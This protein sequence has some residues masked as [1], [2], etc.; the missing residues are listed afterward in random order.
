MM[1]NQ[2]TNID[3]V[4]SL[5][6]SHTVQGG[7][8]TQ[9]A[10]RWYQVPVTGG[11]IGSAT[12][13]STWNPDSS[14][15]FMPSVDVD[16][17]GDMA[18]GYSVS[19]STQFPAI[20]YAGRLASD[21]INTLSQTE[22]S[23]IEGTG[24]QTG[25]CGGSACTRW[26]DYSAM[27]LDPNGCTFWYANEYYVTS[28]L[29][30]HTRIGSF[31]FP[32]CSP[33]SDT[34]PP[35][36]SSI[37]RVDANPTNG[38]TVH[39]TVVFSESVTGVDSSDF[40][41][42]NTG[43]TSPSITGVSGS[44]TSY[45]VTASTGAGSGSL[46]LNLVDDD[47]ITDAAGNKLGGTGTGNGNLIG[48]VYT[49][50]KTFPSVSSIV[51]AD[52]N[53]TNAGS[54]HWTVTFSEPVT[55]VDSTDFALANTGLS[56]PSISGVSGSGSTYT[57]TA[58]TGT[59]S[60]SLGL[61]LT[62]DDSITDSTGNKL[63]GT[64]TGNGDFTGQVYAIDTIAPT[65][66]LLPPT[67]L[68]GPIRITF[69]EI[70]HGITPGDVVL[71]ERDSG[72]SVANTLSCFDGTATPVT[73]LTG[74]VMSAQ[75]Q[76]TAPLLTGQ[77]YTV[78]VNPSGAGSSVV[79]GAGNAEAEDPENFRASTL[80]QQDT[81]DATYRWRTI[82]SSHAYGGSYTTDHLAGAKA[83][84]VLSGTSITWFTTTGPSQGLAQVVIDGIA[85][86]TF[87]Q[88]AP[89][90]HFKVARRVS[91]LSSG[92][93]TVSIIAKGRKGAPAGTGS[94]VSIDAFKAGGNVIGTP[95]LTYTWRRVRK[96]GAL[97]GSYAKSDLAGSR[98]TFRFR[99]TGLDAYTLLS[100][101]QGKASVFVDGV[102]MATVD[103]YSTTA[104]FGIAWSSPV[105]TDDVH[106]VRITVLGKKRSSS[107]GRSVGVD[108]F[109]V[110]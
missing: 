55:G 25:N 12:Q 45:T 66:T 41:L 31:T 2:Y 24:S 62:D 72:T 97:G 71:K 46:G 93:H 15:R 61:N 36:V 59:G 104:H 43:L 13:A 73:C 69:S 99:G 16:D 33:V 28:G 38:S 42:A 65:S 49:I 107:S 68:T 19:S 20:R 60:G 57:V 103:D 8:A 51:R 89:T 79:D 63:G 76:P 54:V 6:D 74:D 85:K 35:T 81:P 34:T 101:D 47:S 56:S 14:N 11:T 94:F 23:L 87:D 39:W 80:V 92:T 27:T 67:S 40:S 1:Q 78:E 110:L 105:L 3:G 95:A 50:D 96:A 30:D 90:A 17:Q 18:I 9:S 82:H 86:G 88:Y 21:P 22:T 98:V 44:G 26:G 106:T 52:T 29:N 37:N 83:T 4:G 58:S 7:S 70:V 84:I 109:H 108:G 91:G 48:Q 77:Y 75:L 5:W 10:V 102:K 53:P 32:G 100:P 64:G